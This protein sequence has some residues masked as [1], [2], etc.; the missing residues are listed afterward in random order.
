LVSPDET[1]NG[2]HYERDEVA[3]EM[4]LTRCSV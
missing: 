3:L 1:E 2:V 4:D